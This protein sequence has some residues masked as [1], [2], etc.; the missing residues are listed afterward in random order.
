MLSVVIAVGTPTE[1]AIAPM[2]PE[3]DQTTFAKP[4]R[5]R[6]RQR[7]ARRK[8]AARMSMVVI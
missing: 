6:A 7:E 4:N 8:R 2:A 1:L 5:P 3:K